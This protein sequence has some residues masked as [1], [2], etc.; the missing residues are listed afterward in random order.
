MPPKNCLRLR[1]VK[2]QPH[3]EAM[4]LRRAADQYMQRGEVMPARDCLHDLYMFN[5]ANE[6]VFQELRAIETRPGFVET[7]K[8]W[9]AKITRKKLAN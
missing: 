9:N 5:P 8:P 6:S 1:T 7:E 2:S 3:E 4:I